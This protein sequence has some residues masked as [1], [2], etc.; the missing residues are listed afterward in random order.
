MKSSFKAKLHSLIRSN[1]KRGRTTTLNAIHKL[2]EKEGKKQSTAERLL[3][4]SKDDKSQF[5][6]ITIYNGKGNVIGYVWGRDL[7]ESKI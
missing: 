6:V 4:K 7:T 1:S 5:E 2:A 3:R